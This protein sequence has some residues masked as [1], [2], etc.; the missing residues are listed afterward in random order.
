MISL[1][2]KLKIYLKNMHRGQ[3]GKLK[4]LQKKTVK[5]G[6]KIMKNGRGGHNEYSFII[7]KFS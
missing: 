2:K 4:N 3:Y 5:N 6:E 1:F 7:K